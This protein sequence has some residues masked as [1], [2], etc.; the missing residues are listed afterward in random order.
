MVVVAISLLIIVHRDFGLLLRGQLLGG[1]F[2]SIPIRFEPIPL[3]LLE[4]SWLHS[5]IS[6][7]FTWVYRIGFSLSWGARLKLDV[8]TS[9]TGF[10]FLVTI[11]VF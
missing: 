4:G 8:A 1:T 6:L 3:L 11:L 5:V 10:R 2:S 7:P 9:Y